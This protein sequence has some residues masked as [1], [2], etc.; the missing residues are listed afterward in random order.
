MGVF[1]L[2]ILY[3]L[4]SFVG[5]VIG[6]KTPQRVYV[7]FEG[8]RIKLKNVG[9]N[10]EVMMKIKEEIIKIIEKDLDEQINEK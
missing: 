5:F 4:G 7:Y 3:L 8:K 10:K 6:R 1:S 9:A 2:F